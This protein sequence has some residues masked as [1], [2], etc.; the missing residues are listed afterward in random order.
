MPYLR[1]VYK[2]VLRLYVVLDYGVF[3][4]DDDDL[5]EFVTKDVQPFEKVKPIVEKEQPARPA[6]KK[7]QNSDKPFNTIE[8]FENFQAAQPA[9]RTHN[10]G[11]DRR[12]AERLRKG[13]IPIEGRLDLHG[14]NQVEAQ[15]A[16]KG[17]IQASVARG[18]RCVLII[19][20]KGVGADGRLDPLVRGEGV[21]R[22]KLPEWLNEPD[23]RGHILKT[24][25]AR[26]QHGGD[27]AMYVLLRR[28][29]A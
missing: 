17:F 18:V 25:V 26:P 5:W 16:V 2:F 19:T 15:V 24:A 6:R 3:M 22:Q 28:K 20:G 8:K 27:G 21:L 29:R 13:Q 9:E 10:P 14:L 12:T 1:R 4:S 11:I 23:I 7:A